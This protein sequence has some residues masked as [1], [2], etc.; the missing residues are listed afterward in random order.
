MIDSEILS[1]YLK[2]KFSDKCREQNIV[3][4]LSYEQNCDANR[5]HSC[6]D[7]NTE[8]CCAYWVQNL[9]VTNPA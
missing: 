2:L 3:A 5:I 8:E 6:C 9:T 1:D 4:Q 7:C